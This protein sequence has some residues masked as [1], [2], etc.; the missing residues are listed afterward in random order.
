MHLAY[1]YPMLGA[2]WTI[3]W[4]FLWIMW[5]FLLFKVIVD[6]FRDDSLSGWGKTGWAVFL[7]VLPYLGVFVYLLA[8]GK[9]MGRRDMEH[10][11]QQRN[12]FDAYVKETAGSN[13][14]SSADELAKLSE[15]RTRGDITQQEFERAKAL[16]L[17][18]S[19]RTSR[20]TSATSS[21][22]Q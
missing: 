4:F 1:D 11:R 15:L 17:N 6:V 12:A 22:L 10:T 20:T 18:D 19:G 8:R 2:F 5:I 7:I 13:R 9:G 14:P 3:L 16:V 21:G